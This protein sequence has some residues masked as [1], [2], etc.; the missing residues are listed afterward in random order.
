L[1]SAFN[2]AS[3]VEKAQNILKRKEVSLALSD[4]AKDH[5]TKKMFKK[6]GLEDWFGKDIL[7]QAITS[8]KLVLTAYSLELVGVKL[9]SIE[10]LDTAYEILSYAAK[11]FEYAGVYLDLPRSYRVN[12]LRHA[13]VCYDAGGFPSNSIVMAHTVLKDIESIKEAMETIPR[14]LYLVN[15][16]IYS[17]LARKFTH[18]ETLYKRI[19]SERINVQE[20][21]KSIKNEQEQAKEIVRLIGFLNVSQA[22]YDF[23]RFLV[24][25]DSFSLDK[26]D[27]AIER[28]IRIFLDSN[29]S[30][31]FTLTTLL[32]VVMKEIQK[33]SV[34][35]SIQKYFK[36]I[37]YLCTALLFVFS[38]AGF[39]LATRTQI[40]DPYARGLL[41]GALLASCLTALPLTYLY[42]SEKEKKKRKR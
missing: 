6:Y 17:F 2:V 21:I 19:M 41:D 20:V 32:S 7:K 9:I 3:L 26:S 11:I 10:K 15:L 30:E 39:T 38:F 25:G 34:W 36:V 40:S 27:G 24:T 33:R 23:Y 29:D 37:Q 18:I 5:Y 1:I 16:L 4:I 42:L 12:L 31:N 13:A 28:G 8:E 14:F 35:K 22:I